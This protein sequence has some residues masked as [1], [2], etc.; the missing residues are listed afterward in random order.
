MEQEKIDYLQKQI[1]LY[2]NEEIKA[3]GKKLYLDGKVNYR[4]Y[5]KETDTYIYSVKGGQNYKVQLSNLNSNNLKCS[6]S[7]PFI[8]GNICK[9]GVASIYHLMDFGGAQAAP[10]ANDFNTQELNLRTADG[11]LLEGYEKITVEIVR[12]NTLPSLFSRFRYAYGSIHMEI[13]DIEDNKV[14]FV[15]NF[16]YKEDT[17]WF[18]KKGDQVFINS[19]NQSIGKGLSESEIISLLKISKSKTTDMLDELLNQKYIENSRHLMEQYGLPVNASFHQFFKF[20]FHPDK[21]LTP[22]NKDTTIGLLPVN[23]PINSFLQPLLNGVQPQRL[24]LQSA[25]IDLKQERVIGFLMELREETSEWN[26]DP[27]FEVK[28]I[29]GKPNKARTQISSNLDFY[30]GNDGSFNVEK[31]ATTEELLALLDAEKSKEVPYEY[32]QWQ[33]KVMQLLAMEPYVYM[34]NSDSYKIRKTD[35]R[36]IKIASKPIDAFYKVV[37]DSDFIMLQLKLRMDGKVLPKEVISKVYK[38]QYV[39][40]ISNQFCV[41]H[42]FRVANMINS[43]LHDVKMVRSQKVLFWQD[44]I[45]PLSKHVEIDFSTGAYNVE[46]IELDFHNK[47]VYLSEKENY[48][49]VTPEVEYHHMVSVPLVNTGDILIEEDGKWIQYKRNFELEE[50]F[51]EFLST[52]HPQF[53]EQVA[54]RKFYLQFNEFVDGLWFYRFYDSLIRN[55]VEVFGLNELKKFKYSPHKGKISTTISSGLDWFEVDVQVSFGDNFVQLADIRKAVKNN[56]RYIQLS[57]GSVGILPKEWYHRF[58]KYFRHGEVQDNKLTVSK[59]GFSIIDELFDNIDNA[60]VL[61]ELSEKHRRLSNFTQIEETSVPTSITAELRPYQKEGLNWLNF[62]NEMKWGG[63]LADDM[64]LGKT[65]QVLTFLQ[66]VLKKNKT[67]NLIVVPTSLLFNWENEIRKFAPELNAYYHYGVGRASNAEGFKEYDLV[68]T[69][70]GVLLRDVQMLSEF[71]FNYII[72]DESQAIKNPAS[73]RYKAACTLKAYNRLALTGTPIENSTFDLFAQMSFVNRGFLGGVTAFKE[74]YSNPIDK[75][76]D[77]IRAAE[78]QKLINPFV[79]RRTKEMVATELPDK[80]EDVIYCEMEPAQRRV[81]DA[82]RNQF[83]DKLMGQIESDGLAKSKMMVLEALTRL[84]QICDSPRLL[85]DESIETS[86]SAKVEE[87]VQHIT[88]KTA[89]H[90]L[91]IFSQFV[92]MLG[93]IRDELQKRNIKFEYLD[94]QSSTKQ[95]EASVNNFQEDEELRVFLI[96]LKAGGTGLNL[97]AADYVYIVDP[98][99]NPAVENQAIDR[100]YRIGQDK[101]VFAYRMICKN[102]VEEKILKLQEK[103]TKI[104]NDIVQTDENIMKNI[105]VDDIQDLFS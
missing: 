41:P 96:S 56:Q 23:N 29:I 55:D 62:L 85:N 101:K 44:V 34:Q 28:A 79:L 26:K 13:G 54:E 92:K 32:F 80:T 14:E 5:N 25:E 100:C 8:W 69:S 48:L 15:L 45:L 35:L 12:K 73:R 57:D 22:I 66:H 86:A 70:Y 10:A 61:E 77:E 84:R 3:K 21:G 7:C 97:T 99:W 67:T 11:Y 90:K 9:H 36:P 50:G 47:R 52:L 82:Y 19:E 16:G 95:R 78:L 30:D 59:L 31:Q 24:K 39:Y 58:E 43:H 53:E 38:G 88:E 94:G 68:I 6:C 102:T 75:D 37:E 63:I 74:N 18:E 81:Y 20:Q 105:G 4:L 65:L 89:N 60:E 71:T 72:L 1:D 103:K 93:L 40:E 83:R 42:D 27:Y 98:W 91:L 46:V 33:Q 17:V 104:A 2:A 76:G 49:I 51:A 64:G 87:L